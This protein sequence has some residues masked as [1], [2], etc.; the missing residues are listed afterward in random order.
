MRGQSPVR[1][2]SV[3][4]VTGTTQRR[5]EVGKRASELELPLGSFEERYGFVEEFESVLC[6]NE[7]LGA[8]GRSQRCG[9]SPR[10][11]AL[12]G[13]VGELLGL[14]GPVEPHE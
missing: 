9:C 6:V 5:P 2:P 7:A 11:R 8:Q 13:I 4:P 12:Y 1:R 14:G 3:D 10:S